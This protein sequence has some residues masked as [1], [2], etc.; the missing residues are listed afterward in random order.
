MPL[1]PLIKGQIAIKW[2]VGVINIPF[3]YL[4]RKVLGNVD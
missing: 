2:A 4:N 1:L 3:M